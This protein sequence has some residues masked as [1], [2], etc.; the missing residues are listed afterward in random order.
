MKP[1]A[2]LASAAPITVADV[3]VMWFRSP[4]WCVKSAPV[5]TGTPKENEDPTSSS[6]MTVRLPFR[7]DRHASAGAKEARGT[8]QRIDPTASPPTLQRSPPP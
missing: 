2:P 6:H 5:G 1:P 3:K 4:G 7:V 8:S